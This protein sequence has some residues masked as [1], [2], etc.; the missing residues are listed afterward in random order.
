MVEAHWS[1]IARR[2]FCSKCTFGAG[3]YLR[4]MH[5][6]FEILPQRHIF[7]LQWRLPVVN[8]VVTTSQFIL[9]QV[10]GRSF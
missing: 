5:L 10:L 7:V 8:Q 1:S 2:S 9:L 3:G 4:W 6:I